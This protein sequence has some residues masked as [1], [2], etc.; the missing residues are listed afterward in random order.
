MFK[1]LWLFQMR[2]L[3][4]CLFVLTFLIDF[5]QLEKCS[6]MVHPSEVSEHLNL[7]IMNILWGCFL[8]KSVQ[9]TNFRLVGIV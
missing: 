6:V 5:L 2:D 8:V 1:L 7:N 9:C 4:I 3:H